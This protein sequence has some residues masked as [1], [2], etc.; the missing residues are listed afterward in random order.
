MT[1]RNDDDRI[2][3]I[4]S[5][6]MDNEPDDPYDPGALHTRLEDMGYSS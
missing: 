6:I 4:I 5:W 2:R 3:E 1:G